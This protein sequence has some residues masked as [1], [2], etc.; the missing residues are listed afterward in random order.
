MSAPPRTH[1]SDQA[2]DAQLILKLKAQ[3]PWKDLPLASYARRTARGDAQ[4]PLAGI[5]GREARP[6]SM[7]PRLPKLHEPIGKTLF[8][9]DFLGGL[10]ACPL[11]PGP[12]KPLHESPPMSG[13]APSRLIN[14]PQPGGLFLRR[15]I[16]SYKRPL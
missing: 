1:A 12:H 11:L 3:L 15:V 14:P 5:Q 6:P 16:R 9:L 4:E 2:V 10:E 7:D 13:L 8:A